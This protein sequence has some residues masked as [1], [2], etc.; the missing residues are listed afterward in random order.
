MNIRFYLS[1]GLLFILAGLVIGSPR[2]THYWEA[3]NSQPFIPQNVASAAA[4]PQGED[5]ITGEPTHIQLPRENISI[6]IEPGYYNQK[7][8]AW[9]LSITKAEYATVTPMPNNKEGNTFIYGHNRMSVFQ[10]LLNAKPGDQAI[11][12]TANNH[13]FTYRMMSVHDTKPNDVSLFNYKGDPILTL[14][15]CSGLWYQNR[16]MFVFSLESAT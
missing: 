9:T 6:D 14:Q 3:K 2:L 4:K 8:G 13:T 12:T 11:I 15:T 5:V 16:R 7:S 1:I 10:K